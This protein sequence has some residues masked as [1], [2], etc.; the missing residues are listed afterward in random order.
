MA[1]LEAERLVERRVADAV[2]RAAT[3]RDDLRRARNELSSSLLQLDELRVDELSR[4]AAGVVDAEGTPPEAMDCPYQGLAAFQRGDAD[5]FFGREP[6]VASI[7]A[8]LASSSLIGVIGASGSGKSSIV[9][10][11][12]LPALAGDSLPGSSSWLS[13]VVNPGSDPLAALAAQLCSVESILPQSDMVA[14]LHSGGLAAVGEELIASRP[15]LTRLLVV[16]DQF[17]EIFTTAADDVAVEFM[18]LLVT[19]AESAHISVVIVLRADFYGHCSAHPGFAS[20]LQDSQILVGPMSRSE[21]HRA[22]TAPAR[23]VGLVLEPGVV[24]AIMYDA[25]DEPG[26]L[27]LVSTALLETFQRRRGRSLTLTAYAEAGGVR[28]AI[29]RLADDVYAAVDDDGRAEIRRVLLRLASPGDETG[30]VRRRV[31][32]L[33]NRRLR[34][35][36]GDCRYLGNSTSGHDRRSVRGGRS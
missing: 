27:P 36:Q 31:L 26:L 23:V 15:G 4:A 30:D 33:R 35:R 3:V 20:E 7:V 28:G 21:L 17:E 25:D 32:L 8:K 10:A 14:R 18:D 22:I 9:R 5:W 6:I 29:A 11:G 1:R 13:V 12:V 19:A 16:I 24:D 34:T 2:N